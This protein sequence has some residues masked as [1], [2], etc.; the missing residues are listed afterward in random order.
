MNQLKIRRHGARSIGAVP[1]ILISWLYAVT[2]RG[3]ASPRKMFEQTGANER[4]QS[5]R[6][7][8]DPAIEG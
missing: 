7:K 2:L 5:E 6:Q 8:R 3:L 4:R 1:F